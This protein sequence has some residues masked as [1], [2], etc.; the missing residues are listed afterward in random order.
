MSRATE[1]FSM[2]SDMSIRVMACSSSNRKAAKVRAN[3]VLPTPVGPRNMNE[4]I[5]RFGSCNPARARLT[6][7][8]TARTA[9][10][11]PITRLPSSSSMRSSLSFSPSSIFSTG[12][13][14]HRDTT[15]AM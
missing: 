13:P 7:V 4:P 11:C 14:V 6:A 5:G 15:P 1:C 10:A 9:S 3:S 12:M 2:Y 8:E